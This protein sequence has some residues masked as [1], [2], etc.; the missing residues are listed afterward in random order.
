MA[1]CSLCSDRSD[2]ELMELTTDATA[3]DVDIDSVTLSARCQQ[4]PL[5]SHRRAVTMP[6]RRYGAQRHIASR[7]LH[8]CLPAIRAHGI[9]NTEYHLDCQ[10]G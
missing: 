1:L 5:S 9:D 6:P 3:D 10:S 4:R 2:T 7:L 8:H